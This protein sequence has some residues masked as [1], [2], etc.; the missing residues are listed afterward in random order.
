ML[1]TS[2]PDCWRKK[3]GSEPDFEASLRTPS[4]AH[5]PSCVASTSL[6][7]PV[8]RHCSTNHDPKCFG[9]CYYLLSRTKLGLQTSH[10]TKHLGDKR[11]L[12]AAW[13]LRLDMSSQLSQL[14]RLGG[15]SSWQNRKNPKNTC[16]V[17]PVMRCRGEWPHGMSKNPMRYHLRYQDQEVA[18]KRGFRG[19][20]LRARSTSQRETQASAQG[21]NFKTPEPSWSSQTKTKYQERMHSRWPWQRR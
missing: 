8:P 11:S 21:S 4:K 12:V 2:V 6:A 16:R 20:R 3:A 13:R 18:P 19:L 17:N 1:L 15:A 10:M 14:E 5:K 7:V 9:G